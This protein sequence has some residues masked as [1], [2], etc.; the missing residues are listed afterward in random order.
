VL[1]NL[2]GISVIGNYPK[3]S[4][5]PSC[6]KIIVIFRR[7]IGSGWSG[8]DYAVGQIFW[9]HTDSDRT[10][11]N[12]SEIPGNPTAGAVSNAHYQ[13][14]R[15][16]TNAATK[17]S[18]QLCVDMASDVFREFWPAVSRQFQQEESYSIKT[19]KQGWSNKPFTV[20]KP[21]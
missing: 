10:Q 11:F 6:L 5:Q 14:N 20:S 18:L 4:S 2:T 8:L 21:I 1:A 19:V 17:L 9:T 7:G 3:R 15:S 13:D 16:A 12:Y